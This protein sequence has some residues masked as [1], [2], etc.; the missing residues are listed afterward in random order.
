MKKL[1]IGVKKMEI[2]EIEISKIKFNPNNPRKEFDKEKLREL[3]DSIKERR[4]INP[5]QVI[6]DIDISKIKLNP[7]NPRKKFDKEKLRELS[8]SIKERGLINPI[9][10]KKVGNDYELICGERRLKAHKLA[11]KKTIKAI[12]KDYNSKSDEMVESL[13]ENLHREDLNSVEKENFITTLWET[14]KYKNRGELA[15][16]IGLSNQQTR[17]IIEVKGIRKKTS[18]GSDISTR[19]IREVIPAKLLEDKKK[20]LGKVKKGEINS[21]KIREVAKVINKSPIDVKQAYFSDKISIQQADKISKIADDKTRKKMI[22]AHKNIKSI[23][24]S[25]ERN[26]EDTKP[27]NKEETIKIKEIIENFR[28]NAIE[29]QKTIQRTTESLLKCVKVINLMDEFQLKRLNHFQDLLE[30]NLSNAL[31][32]SEHI[33][34]KLT[35]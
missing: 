30:I 35:N 32:L 19:D 24:R 11:N 26:F 22:T 28:N 15:R 9:Q 20:I 16:A 34:E 10:V 18:A 23:D 6:V 29:N 12:I 14:G 27:K 31:Q 3:A 13:I 4:L 33:K 17:T 1:K 21:D 7:N 5:I 8:D 2:N 25:I